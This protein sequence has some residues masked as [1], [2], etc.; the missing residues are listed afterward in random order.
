MI[1]TNTTRRKFLR[2]SAF[3]A[4]VTGVA[5]ACKPASGASASAQ[6]SPTGQSGGT[7]GAH[8][9]M[10]AARASAEAMDA[11]HEVGIKAFPAKTAGKG[12]QLLQP[13]IVDGVKI[14][15][16]TAKKI[17]WET[18]PGNFVEA[19]AYNEQVPGPTIRVREHDKVRV[20]LHNQLD[21][22]TAIHFHGLELPNAQDGVP[23][24]T[25]PPVKPGESCTYELI[26]PNAGS[27]M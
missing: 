9:T 4:L 14:Y 22:S 20:V 3:A 7:M 21:Q 8:D 1:D 2:D 13:R 27:H 10:N 19:W 11:M 23:F 6:Y 16:L 24:I 12:G 25:Q 26:V 17:W 18:Q 15:E 5:T